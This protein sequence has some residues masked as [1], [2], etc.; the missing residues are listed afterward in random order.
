MHRYKISVDRILPPVARPKHPLEEMGERCLQVVRDHAGDRKPDL[1][2][3]SDF[4]WA[5]GL[6][7][8]IHLVRKVV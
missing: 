8:K 7:P 5:L 4:C 1:R 2:L 6:D 3:L